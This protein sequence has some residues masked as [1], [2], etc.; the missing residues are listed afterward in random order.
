[1]LLKDKVCIVTGAAL[2]IGAGISELF[3]QHGASVYLID[4]DSTANESTA[5][6]IRASGGRATALT[7]DVSKRA[8]VKAAVDRV[9]AA[10]GRIDVLINNAG[11]YP[12]QDFL[13]LTEAEW[14]QMLDVNLKSVF[15]FCQ[16]VLPG[17][18]ARRSGK[19]V[20]IASV[21]IFKGTERLSHYVASKGGML[22]LSRVMAREMGRHNVHINVVT[23]GAIKTEGEAIVHK[24][25]KVLADLQA[26]Q[27][28]DRRLVPVDVAGPCLFLASSLSDGMT[29]QTLNVDGGL[30]L[31]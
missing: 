8:G 13:A 24:D 22:G 3:A 4:I 19:I 1:M 7:A 12:R 6:A 15:H 27:C 9:S 30:V 16:L 23:P 21:T 2:G 18:V 17:M 10:E 20:N 25:P 5:A 28:L 11:I 29:G 26:A 31:Y 14:D